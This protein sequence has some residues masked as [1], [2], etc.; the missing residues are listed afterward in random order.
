MK[1]DKFQENLSRPG[2]IDGK[3]RYRATAWLLKNTSLH[4]EKRSGYVLDDREFKFW[5]VQDIFL[6]L[7]T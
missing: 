7:Q 4:D 3:A 2:I 6:F 1:N 5:W